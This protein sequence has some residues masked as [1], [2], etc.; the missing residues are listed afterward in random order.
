MS[1]SKKQRKAVKRARIQARKFTPAKLFRLALKTL[2]FAVVVS[3][4]IA[5][6]VALDV[7]VVDERWF[8]L[9]FMGVCYIIAFPY[10]FSEFRASG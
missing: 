1:K 10:V 9:L 8:Q 4:F 2:V 7:A 6:L 3:I 5:V